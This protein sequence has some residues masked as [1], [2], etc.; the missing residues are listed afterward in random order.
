MVYHIDGNMSI[1]ILRIYNFFRISAES[2]PDQHQGAPNQSK[3]EI[4]VES[5]EIK[6]KS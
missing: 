1:H 3:K 4:S 2:A 6:K 5:Q